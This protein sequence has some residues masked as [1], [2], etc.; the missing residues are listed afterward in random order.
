MNLMIHFSGY[1][2]GKHTDYTLHTSISNN[3]NYYNLDDVHLSLIEE[4]EFREINNTLTI[5][6]YL[7]DIDLYL[8][9]MY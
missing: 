2:P 3:S 6:M 7:F 4:I 9:Q 1:T 5:K 8:K